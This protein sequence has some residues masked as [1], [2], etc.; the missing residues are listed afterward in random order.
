MLLRILLHD[1]RCYIDNII[2]L[3]FSAIKKIIKIV[4]LLKIFKD[5]ILLCKAKLESYRDTLC[6][7]Q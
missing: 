1:Y 3:T 2:L 4:C 6:F 7:I 5:S